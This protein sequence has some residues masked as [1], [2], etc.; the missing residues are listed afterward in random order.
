MLASAPQPL[1]PIAGGTDLLVDL[2][3]GRHA[4]VQSLLD[5]TAVEELCRLEIRGSALFVGAAVPLSRLVQSSLVRQHAAAL[6]DA[7]ELIGG[8][9]VRNVAT[10]GGNVAHALPAA[11]GTIALLALDAQVQVARADRVE[12]VELHTLFLGPGRSSLAAGQDLLVG[13]NVP[14]RASGHASAFKRIMRPQGVA[15]PILNL[16]VWLAREKEL[17]TDLRIAAGPGA[18]VPW[19]ARQVEQ[20]IAGHLLDES[21]MALAQDALLAAVKFRTSA[22]RASEEY[23]RHLVVGLL[24]ETLASAWE[25]AGL[26]LIPSQVTGKSAHPGL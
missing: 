18:A 6:V 7:C 21:T 22:R 3:Q 26:E 10:L 20:V 9:Q 17:V 19:R 25:R 13:F 24:R 8:P 2:Q 1:R 12:E 4:P 11:D 15:L 14:L 23:R 16:A 5:L